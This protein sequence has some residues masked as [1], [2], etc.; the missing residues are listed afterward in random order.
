MPVPD[1]PATEH[2][3]PDSDTGPWLLTLTWQMIDGLPECVDVRVRGLN[4]P[5]PITD[6]AIR[7]INVSQRIARDRARMMVGQ[8]P[9]VTRPA[10]MRESTFERL[11]LAARTY[12]EALAAGSRTPNRAVQELLG[13]SQGYAGNLVFKA[14]EIGLLPPTS[15][16]V[17]IGDVSPPSI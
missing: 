3:Y 2:R 12:Q 13:V 11:K 14:R 9:A 5:R 16:G 7:K 15:S 17:A 4:S 8:L 6:A 1:L 10:R